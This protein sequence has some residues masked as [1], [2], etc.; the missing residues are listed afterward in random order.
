MKTILFFLTF[1]GGLLYASPLSDSEKAEL[2]EFRKEIKKEV[3]AN[4][5][6]LIGELNAA[7]D[8][9][10]ATVDD[11][12]KSLSEKV[13]GLLELRKE[14]PKVY[15]VLWAILEKFIS[16]KYSHKKYENLNET[17]KAELDEKKK[18]VRA[19]AKKLIG[20]LSAALDKR[21]AILDDKSKTP[22]EKLNALLELRKENSNAND[23]LD[24][25]FEQFLPKRRHLEKGREPS[26]QLNDTEK[27]RREELIKEVRANVTKLI[28]ELNAAM[29]KQIAIV[30]DKSKTFKEKEKA[31]WE[32]REQNP[33]VYNVLWA[34][35]EQFTPKFRHLGK[36]YRKLNDTEK[37]NVNDLIKE[38]RANVT[39]LI[40]ELS[41]VFEKRTAIL[42]DKSKTPKEKL[43]ALWELRKENPKANY[44]V[45]V[46]FNQ[47][48]RRR[49]SRVTLSNQPKER[50]TDMAKLEKARDEIRKDA[51]K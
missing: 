10:I 17:E 37:E 23:I 36:I 22:K 49:R 38:V 1:L 51:R 24:V 19:N 5:T 6:K 26:K 4:V 2:E 32:L 14:N 29:D 8:K 35:Y 30:D 39:K 18:E 27:A 47:F 25:T 46:A 7:L 11:K 9:H 41:A 21:T 50:P 33:K 42:D 20:E 34:I 48:N 45:D 16:Q 44:I 43:K 3:R 15:N 13:K 31:I 40:G 12:S 28:G